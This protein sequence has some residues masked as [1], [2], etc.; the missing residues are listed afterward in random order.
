MLEF[1][2]SL[3]EARLWA[4]CFPVEAERTSFVLARDMASNP[5]DRSLAVSIVGVL[6]G[7]GNTMAEGLL[8]HLGSS[9]EKTVAAQAAFEL[10]YRDAPGGHLELYQ[11]MA[12]ASELFAVEVLG[13]WPDA[14]S[15]RIL[16]AIMAR[17]ESGGADYELARSS[18]RRISWLESANRDQILAEILGSQGVAS[19][20]DIEWALRVARRLHLP[21][22]PSLLRN[23]MRRVEEEHA[24]FCE[25]AFADADRSAFDRAYRQEFAGGWLISSIDWHFDEFLKAFAECGGVLTGLEAERLDFIGYGPDPR[26]RLLELVSRWN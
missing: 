9:A 15:K 26:R 12:Q 8:A 21:T 11:K 1:R 18:W 19:F 16:E 20:R 5:D 22:L 14:G 24:Q 10:A 17:G 7:A 23:R 13:D 6:S 4:L 25:S 3:T 2:Y